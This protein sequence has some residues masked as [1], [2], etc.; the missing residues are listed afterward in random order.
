MLVTENS[1]LRLIFVITFNGMSHLV[2][3]V[4]IHDTAWS[5]M[6]QSLKFLK[7]LTDVSFLPPTLNAFG[8]FLF[9]DELKILKCVLCVYA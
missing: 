3:Y 8:S 6:K 4:R 5:G 9:N 2:N 1:L 7:S